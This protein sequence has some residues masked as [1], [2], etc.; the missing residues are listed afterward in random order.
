MVGLQAWSLSLCPGNCTTG[1]TASSTTTLS[2]TNRLRWSR[3]L[4]LL[5]LLHLL[6]LLLLSSVVLLLYCLLHL[7]DV[8]LISEK[9]LLL[10]LYTLNH[11]TTNTKNRIYPRSANRTRNRT[12]LVQLLTQQLNFTLLLLQLTLLQH[13][14]VHQNLLIIQNTN[15][16]TTSCLI[17][18]IKLSRQ[19]NLSTA[20][21][22]LAHSQL[23]QLLDKL[24]NVCMLSTLIWW[25]TLRQTISKRHYWCTMSISTIV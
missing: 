14:R 10:L 18:S 5:P 12:L 23:I 6:L 3:I 13:Q 25:F 8:W 17:W 24:I 7:W 16:N 21:I 20:G 4:H 2:H 9:C 1:T 11:R 22:N 19:T 15:T